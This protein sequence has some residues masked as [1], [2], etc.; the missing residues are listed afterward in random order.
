MFL[1][2][3]ILRVVKKIRTTPIA[4]VLNNIKIKSSDL[5]KKLFILIKKIVI[6]LNSFHLFL[7]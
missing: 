1:M 2:K 5:E 3:I 7:L 4:I 6:H